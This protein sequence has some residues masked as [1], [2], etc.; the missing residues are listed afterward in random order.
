[1]LA[2]ILSG[3]AAMF[4]VLLSSALLLFAHLTGRIRRSAAL[5][6]LATAVAVGL[7]LVAGGTTDGFVI[8]HVALPIGV[9]LIVTATINGAMVLLAPKPAIR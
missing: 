1:M 6:L 3:S 8:G 7:G 4:T 9:S 2:S 5:A